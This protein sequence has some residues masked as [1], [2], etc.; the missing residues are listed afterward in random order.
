MQ[1]HRHD[2][3]LQRL[4]GHEL[5]L[6]L[7]QPFYLLVERLDPV[8][9]VD[10]PPEAFREIVEGQNVLRFLRPYL[11]FRVL[12]LPFR[13]ERRHRGFARRLVPLL[14][15]RHEVL[16]HL[17]P[18][19]GPDLRAYVAE[20]MDEASLPFGP[21]IGFGDRLVDAGEPVG[22]G[23]LDLVEPAG[24]EARQKLPVRLRGLLGRYGVAHDQR[25]ALVG[26]AHRYV[27][28]LLGHRIPPYRDVGG[29]QEKG[30][31]APGKPPFRELFH[32]R[33][34]RVGDR[35]YRRPRVV[36]LVYR[37][38]RQPHLL[39]G[40]SRRVE[41]QDGGSHQIGPPLVFGQRHWL[42]FAV[43]VPGHPHGYRPDRGLDRPFVGTVPRIAGVLALGVVFGI[44]EE[45]FDLRLEEGFDRLLRRDRRGLAHRRFEVVASGYR[46]LDQFAKIIHAG[47]L[48]DFCSKSILLG[49][50]LFRRPARP[51]GVLG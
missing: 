26:D 22:D 3:L 29:I 50:L 31:K 46:F 19:P 36:G 34:D 2:S 9:R 12:G 28:G 21:R 42:V 48:S 6:L 11:E 17:G 38:Y 4:L 30:E 13:H 24:F 8:V 35:G 39:V 10:Q 49:I 47:L 16:G 5:D 32:V 25:D 40:H 33:D 45:G 23:D 27:Y 37:A 41:L 44:A 1:E 43:S 20:Q 7:H 18:V 14:G 15:Y 51:L